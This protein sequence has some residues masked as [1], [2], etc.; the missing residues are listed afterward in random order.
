MRHAPLPTCSKVRFS[1]RSNGSTVILRRQLRTT[2]YIVTIFVRAK[3]NSQPYVAYIRQSWIRRN[4][5]NATRAA[6]SHI[7]NRKDLIFRNQFKHRYSSE[8]TVACIIGMYCSLNCNR[9]RY[10]Q[11]R[12]TIILYYICYDWWFYPSLLQRNFIIDSLYRCIEDIHWSWY[13]RKLFIR[14]EKWKE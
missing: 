3:T 7:S 1:S 5:N 11:T 9:D 6:I 12:N 4:R 14:N 2:L 8:R 13:Y 10:Q